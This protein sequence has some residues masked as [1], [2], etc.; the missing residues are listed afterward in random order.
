LHGASVHVEDRPGGGAR[1]VLQFPSR[2]Q[3]A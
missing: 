2:A 3:T 1:F